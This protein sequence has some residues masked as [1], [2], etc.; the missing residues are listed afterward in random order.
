M[1]AAAGAPAPAPRTPSAA[2]RAPDQLAG[3]L[4]DPL[5]HAVEGQVGG[6]ADHGVEQQPE[7][8]LVRDHLVD[9]FEELAQQVVEPGGGQRGERGR[10]RGR[11]R[12]TVGALV[13]GVLVVPM[14]LPSREPE[15]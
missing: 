12:A 14:A 8:A 4:D 15:S 11:V 9:P 3:D 6:D 7:P 2:Y 1:K 13:G 5:Q 10:G